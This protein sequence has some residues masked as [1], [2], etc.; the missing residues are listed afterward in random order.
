MDAACPGKNLAS[1]TTGCGTGRRSEI[2]QCDLRSFMATCPLTAT[3]PVYNT[4][5]CL[6][7]QLR[8]SAVYSLQAFRNRVNAGVWEEGGLRLWCRVWASASH[9][10]WS[11]SRQYLLPTRKG[12][13]LSCSR[14]KISSESQSVR[15][16]AD[17]PE[18]A[19]G[20]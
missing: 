18:E 14:S 3:D 12:V 11:Q 6:C 17:L 20:G 9:F 1:G 8:A 13:Q 19:Y 15:N 16:N 4:S 7:K 5:A 10:G 2:L